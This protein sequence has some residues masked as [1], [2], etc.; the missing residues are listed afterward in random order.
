[1]ADWYIYIFVYSWLPIKVAEKS[2]A[3]NVFARSN[4]GIVGPNPTQDTDVC[5]RLFCVC[6]ALCKVAALRRAD[7]PSKESSRLSKIKKLKWNEAFHGC[8]MLQVGATGIDKWI[9][10]INLVTF[11]VAT[12]IS[13][14]SW[15]INE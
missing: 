5:L 6:V 11:S 9:F 14:N 10:S 2:K 8:H 13:F 12:Y 1:M 15:M 7:P 4:T 3:W